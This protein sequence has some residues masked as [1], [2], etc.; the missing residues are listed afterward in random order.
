M[1]RKLPRRAP[2]TSKR[3]HQYYKGT[4]SG[5]MGWHT[6]RSGYIIDWN[7]VR[8]YV[9]PPDL[10]TCEFKPYVSPKTPKYKYDMT[11]VKYYNL[12]NEK[13]KQKFINS[14]HKNSAIDQPREAPVLNKVD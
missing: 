11:P 12:I 8:T 10:D 14:K 1:I 9:V 13:W 3:G 4:G 6:K 2:M 7:K 5:A